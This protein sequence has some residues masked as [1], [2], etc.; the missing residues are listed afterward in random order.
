MGLVKDENDKKKKTIT[1]VHGGLINLNGIQYDKSKK[2]IYNMRDY[3]EKQQ[4]DFIKELSLEY[5]DENK[6]KKS[7]A[8]TCSEI[9]T[10]NDNYFAGDNYDYQETS[11]LW[12]RHIENFSKDNCK[13]YSSYEP[14]TTFVVGHC[15]TTTTDMGNP[16]KDC[17]DTNKYGKLNCIYP[18][19]FH[20]NSDKPAAIMT[21]VALSS[22]FK[23]DKI[24]PLTE[25]SR[26]IIS[27]V[28]LREKDIFEILLIKIEN[29]DFKFFS[30]RKEPLSGII[31]TPLLNP[32]LLNKSTGGFPNIIKSTKKTNI[33]V[34]N[35]NKKKHRSISKSK[36]VR[37]H[38]KRQ[39]RNKSKKKHN[40]TN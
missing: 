37:Y 36:T 38:R 11:V 18:T 6:I 28:L 4:T 19:C 31:E 24:S 15:Q 27:T 39:H 40:K 13:L 23:K 29:N 3:I 26:A 32:A 33:G 22:A 21:D 20:K 10:T 25:I 34:T 12:N 5:N 35:K 17:H 8:Q 2:K 14:N 30:V 1:F 7:F 9:T 16:R